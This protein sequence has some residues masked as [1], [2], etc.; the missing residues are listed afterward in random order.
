M[1]EATVIVRVEEDLKAAFAQAAKAA[2]RT[3]SQLLRDFMRDYVRAQAERT[4]VEAW[5]REDV[6]AS[7]DEYRA[8][9]DGAIPAADVSAALDARLRARLAKPSGP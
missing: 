5:L 6:A 9:P 4:E 8:D 1:A 7:Y 2:D 3:A